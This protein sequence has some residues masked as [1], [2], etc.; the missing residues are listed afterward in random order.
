MEFKCP[1]TQPLLKY[2]SCFYFLRYL[3]IVGFLPSSFK[4]KKVSYQIAIGNIAWA[5]KQEQNEMERRKSVEHIVRW[6]EKQYAM[7]VQ[8]QTSF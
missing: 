5:E 3:Y 7:Y 6:T 4:N 8:Y 2:F 1:Y